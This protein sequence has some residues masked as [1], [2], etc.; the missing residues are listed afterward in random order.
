M[1]RGKKMEKRVLLERADIETA[2]SKSPIGTKVT[3]SVAFLA[4]AIKVIRECDFESQS[5]PGQAFIACPKALPFVSSG[6]GIRTNNPE[7]YSIRYYHGSVQL[8]L[9]REKAESALS[10]ALIVYTK[11][12]YLNDP[13]V[14]ED[15]K[16]YK[17]I[18]ESNCT[19]ILVKVLASAVEG[20]AP[21]TQR[22][23]VANLAGNNNDCGSWTADEIRQQ[24]K[25]SHSHFSRWCVVAG[26]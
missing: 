24:A 9:V 3:D 22:T 10:C 16:E 21:F 5:T 26:S 25:N 14:K 15:E 20:R 8:F 19:H 13:E 11:D 1:E 17:R 4:E 2:F 12:A 6:E 7:D 18:S 23:L